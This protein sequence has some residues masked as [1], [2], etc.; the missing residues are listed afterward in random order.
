MKKVI[1]GL[2]AAVM[3]VAM[4][5]AVCGRP[6]KQGKDVERLKTLVETGGDLSLRGADLSNAD[7]G[8]LDLRGAMLNGADLRNSDLSNA[9]L[10]GSHLMYAKM[11]GT[12]FEGAIGL[13]PGQKDDARRQGALNVPE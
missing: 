1:N 2:F 6:A 7:L 10:T 11:E 3:L 5:Q 9:D 8:G 13:L 4:G 12:N